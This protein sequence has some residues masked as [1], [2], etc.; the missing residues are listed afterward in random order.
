[1]QKA[2]EI[3]NRIA[4][5]TDRVILFHS[6]SGK[7]SIALLDLL[8]SRFVQICCAY[9]YVVKD[10]S[11]INRYISYAQN[12]YKNAN[13]IQIPHYCVFNYIKNGYMGIEKNEKQREYNLGELTEMIRERTGI[14]WSCYGFK[15][16]DSMNRRLMLRTYDMGAICM[17][18]KKFYP[19][20]VYKNSDA[21]KYISDNMLIKPEIYGNAKSNGTAID[22][23]DYLLF[24]RNNHPD[25]LK[26][27][28]SVFPYCD[29][30]LY[31][32]DYKQN[33]KEK[34]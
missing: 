16:S 17:K 30:L 18:S 5:Q 2:I 22:D 26:K 20:S 32:Y 4:D 11:H 19:L 29:R 15:Q 3:I 25:D 10:L 23:R 24:L 34:A 8:S 33:Q 28:I 12:K 31:E 27:V 7:D 6:A 9:M 21:L 13:F 1:M 14:E